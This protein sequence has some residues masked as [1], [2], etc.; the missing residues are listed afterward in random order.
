M[1]SS[2][3]ATAAAALPVLV[4]WAG[5]VDVVTRA[6]PNKVVMALAACF[7]FFAAT[8]HLPLA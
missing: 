2:L 8:A 3:T 6:I 7:G 4:V 5:A 1:D